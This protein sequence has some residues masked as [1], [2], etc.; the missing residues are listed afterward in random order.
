MSTYNV[1]ANEL[2]SYHTGASTGSE[3]ARFSQLKST[4]RPRVGSDT[5]DTR[6]DALSPV[7]AHPAFAADPPPLR[8]SHHLQHHYSSRLKE[9]LPLS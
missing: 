9:Q 3:P 1:D 6:L 7:S 8:S 2:Y 4:V 5:P